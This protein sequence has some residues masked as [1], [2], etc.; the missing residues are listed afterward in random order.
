VIRW[1]MGFRTGKAYSRVKISD[2][3][4]IVR[5]LRSVIVDG[6]EVLAIVANLNGFN[7]ANGKQYRN[8]LTDDTFV[9][10]GENGELEARLE[11][12]VA[13]RLFFAHNNDGYRYE[14]RVTWTRTF[15]EHGATWREFR[16]V[17]GAQVAARPDAPADVSARTAAAPLR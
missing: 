8:V 7:A 2:E 10:Q 15:E 1:P 16:R 12:P 14:G 3:L 17:P 6:G 11:Q 9:M 13:V 5:D 4:G